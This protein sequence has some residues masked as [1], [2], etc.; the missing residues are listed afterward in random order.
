MTNIRF[1]LTVLV[2]LSAILLGTNSAEA[3]CKP[4][5]AKETS[6]VLNVHN[7]SSYAI[8]FVYITPCGTERSRVDL[9]GPEEVIMPGAERSFHLESGCW[10][11]RGRLS[12]G[13]EFVIESIQLE[14]DGT[15]TVTIGNG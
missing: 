7:E 12:T 3:S 14:A 6:A 4:G 8:H 9:L 13:R 5:R 2:A 15:H 1:Y 10:N 11:L